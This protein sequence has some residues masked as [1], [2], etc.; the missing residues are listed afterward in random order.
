MNRHL[1]TIVKT[2]LSLTSKVIL[3]SFFLCLLSTNMVFIR[4]AASPKEAPYS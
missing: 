1:K 3:Y 2:I 4:S